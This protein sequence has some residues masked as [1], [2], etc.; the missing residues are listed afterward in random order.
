MRVGLLGVGTVGSG[1][2]EMLQDC[3]EIEIVRM[4]DVKVRMPHM[5]TDPDDIFCDESI[6]TVVETMGGIMPAADFARRALN[7]GKHFVTANKALVA[8]SGK[9][10]DALARRQGKAFL[11]GAACGGGIPY[12]RNLLD[13]RRAE[14][15]LAV[16]GILN[17]TTNYMLDL[18]QRSG[19]DYN[20]A[21]RRAQALGYAERDPSAD[22]D[23]I[24]T[25]RK[26]CLACGVAFD[27]WIGENQIPTAGIRGIR[28]EDIAFFQQLGR[29]CRLT[30][31]AGKVDGKLYAYVEPSLVSGA[32]LESGICLNVNAC[33]YETAGAGR[34][35]F[36]G[37]GAGKLPT[38]TNVVC[39]LWDILE[40]R[41]HMFSMALADARVHNEAV[42]R[43]YVLCLPQGVRVEAQ[44]EREEER[45]GRRYV[46]TRPTPVEA[47]H[48]MM[49]KIGEGAFFAGIE[50]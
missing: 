48:Q 46:L 34:K 44:A 32:S 18:M 33:Y 14:Q 28:Q 20:D 37:Q 15:I 1:V 25:A 30:A 2:V 31:H 23:G 45:G 3:M 21:L 10:L 7:A 50:E 6:D 41:R 12:L 4:L 38:A 16:G 42:S 43:R 35:S 22:V 49:R 26:L 8:D 5:T 29:T 11:F 39:D 24:D 17:G 19:G 13:A 36:A 40:G 47:V 9:E 27:A